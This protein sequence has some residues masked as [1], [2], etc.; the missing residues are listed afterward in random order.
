MTDSYR[1]PDENL[2][3]KETTSYHDDD[4]EIQN[5]ESPAQHTPRP[6]ERRKTARRPPP[7]KHYSED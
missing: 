6:A 2:A 5:D 1:D 4:Q 7:R 3:D